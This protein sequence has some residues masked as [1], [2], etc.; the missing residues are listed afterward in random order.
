MDVSASVGVG[1]GSGGVSIHQISETAFWAKQAFMEIKVETFGCVDN[2]EL[3][4]KHGS[5]SL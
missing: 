3:A 1:H 5:G 2:T 4:E